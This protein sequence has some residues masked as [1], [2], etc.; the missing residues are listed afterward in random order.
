[1]KIKNP[2]TGQYYYEIFPPSAKEL[3]AKTDLMRQAQVVW[4]KLDIE[5]RIQAL[6]A[7]K[8]V[9]EEYKDELIDALC[10]DTGRKM[11]TIFE[12]DFIASSIDRDGP[13]FRKIFSQK[14][15]EKTQKYLF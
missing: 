14:P 6:K 5:L 4:A 1:M 3:K 2:R 10:M 13:I 8:A 12:V 11:E 7:W 15:T 9:V